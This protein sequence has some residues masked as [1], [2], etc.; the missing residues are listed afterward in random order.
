MDH[1]EHN[2]RERA[3]ILWERDGRAMGR[4]EHYW[5]LAEQELRA[6]APAVE[7]APRTVAKPR[8]KAAPK[9]PSKAAAA[10]KAAPR[11]RRA[12][13]EGLAVS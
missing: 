10:V 4:D 13:A 6:A 9:P 3:Y 12:A 5:T 7:E 1:C 11:R 8:A 2:I